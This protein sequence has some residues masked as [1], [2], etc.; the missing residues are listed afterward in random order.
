MRRAALVGASQPNHHYRNVCRTNQSETSS[1]CNGT[2]SFIIIVAMVS[3]RWQLPWYTTQLLFFL[4]L[5][6]PLLLLLLYVYWCT[7]SVW[8]MMIFLIVLPNKTLHSVL[9]HYQPPAR[10]ADVCTNSQSGSPQLTR[11]L[12]HHKLS[13]STT[14]APQSCNTSNPDPKAISPT[15][16]RGLP[17][18]YLYSCISCLIWIVSFQTEN[19]QQSCQRSSPIRQVKERRQ[20]NSVY[21]RWHWWQLS[22]SRHDNIDSDNTEVTNSTTC[23]HW[24][25]PGSRIAVTFS[26]CL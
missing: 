10:A 7:V 11:D 22:V 5:L 12:N 8:A 21:G 4:L 15:K 16:V 6:L 2:T 20:E 25:I 13:A 24:P 19:R 26:Y 1:Y 17:I 3:P 9:L 18:P 14:H 23:Y